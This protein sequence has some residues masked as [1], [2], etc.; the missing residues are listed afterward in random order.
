MHKISK[1]GDIDLEL[2]E[3][4]I[5]QQSQDLEAALN[6]IRH[7]KAQ[8]KT[9]RKIAPAA[10][11]SLDLDET[12]IGDSPDIAEALANIRRQRTDT[13]HT[14]KKRPKRAHKLD[15]VLTENQPP[16]TQRRTQKASVKS[17]G[18]NLTV[19]QTLA[20]Q[21]YSIKA[22]LSQD[23]VSE[24]YL[25]RDSRRGENIAIRVLNPNVS[26]GDKVSFFHS[27]Q[28]AS[29]LQ[30]ENIVHI[31]DAQHEQNLTYASMEVSQGKSLRKLIAQRQKQN[32]PF[33]ENEV[34]EIINP[35]CDALSYVH[36]QG[37]H[38]DISPKNIWLDVH[39]NSKLS[40]FA[41]INSSSSSK[42][43]LFYKAPE[44]RLN[45]STAT[46]QS[47]QYSLAAIAYEMAT[48]SPPREIA[49]PLH[50]VRSDLNQHFCDAID[51]ALQPQGMRRF[52]EIET[53]KTALNNR[54]KT[55]TAANNGNG[56]QNKNLTP[57]LIGII[58]LLAL[59]VAAMLIL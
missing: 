21:R 43:A 35:L 24:L 49:V 36:Q 42:K 34:L 44:Q 19:G 11:S 56:V 37:S 17:A 3:T 2:D 47:D 13:K 46:L 20:Y 5:G 8:P 52:K 45:A 28:R 27:A 48:G 59:T 25:A 23:R 12:I 38:G 51:K 29:E 54:A 10:E 30:H 55:N 57:I 50:N 6:N 7:G 9:S 18:K 26:D 15:F 41:R 16:A 22:F 32:S 58:A 53:F 39:N 1:Q 4:L 14:P 33:Q 40:G 31:Y